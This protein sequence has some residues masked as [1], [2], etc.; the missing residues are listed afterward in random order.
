MAK[1]VAL[2]GRDERS[3]VHFPPRRA[4]RPERDHGPCQPSCLRSANAR[5]RGPPRRPAPRARPAGRRRAP[6]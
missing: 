1:P 2:D 6:K 5:A 4:P 3:G